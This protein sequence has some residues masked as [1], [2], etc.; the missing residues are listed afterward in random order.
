MVKKNLKE[1]SNNISNNTVNDSSKINEE[2]EIKILTSIKKTENQIEQNEIKEDI[3]TST[4]KYVKSKPKNILENEL[5]IVNKGTGAGGSNTNYYGK[6]FEEKTDNS[7]NLIKEGYTQNKL[8]NKF[9]YLEMITDN[10]TIIVAIQSSL[11]MYMKN[12]YD[13]D[14]FRFP[15]EAYIITDNILDKNLHKKHIKILEKKEQNVEGSVE[16]KL[17]SAIALKREYELVLGSDFI[18]SYA[19]CVNDFLKKK[20]TSTIKKYVILNQIFKENDIV[21]LFGD[22]DDYFTS[23]NEWINQR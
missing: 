21:V 5:M 1:C 4:R 11:K 19:F 13:I 12:V 20:I 18:V 8:S 23:L 14:L 22:D 17:W 10:K 7:I 16:T 2:G 15:D 6:K 9:G 3:K